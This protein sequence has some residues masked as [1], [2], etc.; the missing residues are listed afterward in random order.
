MAMRRIAAFS[1]FTQRIVVLPRE[2]KSTEVLEAQLVGVGIWEEDAAG[3]RREHLAP[4]V[5][6][7]NYV[8]A[9]GWRFAENAFGVAVESG[10]VCGVNA[11]LCC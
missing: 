2:P 6:V 1:A 4:E 11:C 10:L 5:F 7:P 3:A 8:K 9:A